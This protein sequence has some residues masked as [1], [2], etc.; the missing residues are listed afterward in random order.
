MEK[1]G[2]GVQRGKWV[3]KMDIWPAA[4]LAARRQDASSLQSI[5]VS[6]QDSQGRPLSFTQRGGGGCVG[7]E[8]PGEETSP[9]LRR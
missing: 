4:P 3:T 9:S 8:K 6:Q 2:S 5:Y 7:G 1:A